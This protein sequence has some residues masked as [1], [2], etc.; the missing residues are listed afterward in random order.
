MADDRAEPRAVL[1]HVLGRVLGQHAE[2]QRLVRPARHA[3]A[4]C[5]RTPPGRAAGRRRVAPSCQRNS[6]PPDDIHDRPARTLSAARRPRGPARRGALSCSSAGEA[7][8]GK[9][10]LVR[11]LLRMRGAPARAGR[12]VRCR[13]YTPRPLGPLADI[14]ASTGGELAALVADGRARE[15]ARRRAGRASCGAQRSRRRARGPA[16]GRRARP[17]TCCACSPAASTAAARSSSAPTATTSSTARIRCGSCSASCARARR[18][19]RLEPLSLDGVARARAAAALDAD[20]LHR[21]TGGNPFFVTEVVAAGGGRDPGDRPRRGARPRGAARP[22]ARDAA[23]RRRDRPAARRARGCSRRSRP[24]SRRRSTSA[25]LGHAARRGRRRPLPPRDRAARD[26]GRRSRRTGGSRC[27]GARWRRSRRLLRTSRALAHHAEA[28][29]DA[30]AVLRYAPAAAERA[31]RAAR[32]P[33]GRGAPRARA[34]LRR[35]ARRDRARRAARAALLRVLPD[36]RHRRRRSPR[37]GARWRSTARSATG[38]ARVTRIAGS[39][40]SPGS[41]ATTPPPSG[42][43]RRAVRAARTARRRPR[44][45]ARLQQPLPALHAG[46][47]RSR[48]RATGARAR[49]RSPRRW[50]RPRSLVSRAQQRR[51]RTALTAIS[52]AAAS[53]S[54]AA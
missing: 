29:G 20:E 18:Q 45:R 50:A 44:A 38:C 24:R 14:A 48:H 28:A 27:T 40:A 15:R 37:A 42:R 19:R 41:A 46:H 13:C 43:P 26:R 16:L 12:R 8:I 22:G 53:C 54:S 23:R 1:G 7:G 25:C 49:S 52:R 51:H 36:R 3:A 47:G 11:A 4:P 6:T 35:T 32:P 9:T 33:R 30:D 31:A 10:R 5:S 21:R 39:H 34:A 17:S 2:V